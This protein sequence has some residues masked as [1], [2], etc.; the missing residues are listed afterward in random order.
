MVISAELAREFIHSMEFAYEKPP[1]AS[2][3][4]ESSAAESPRAFEERE[5][6][7]ARKSMPIPPM[8]IIEWRH[9]ASP[10]QNVAIH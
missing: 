9:P 4:G 6:S 5:G 7:A 10:H 8:K 3:R 2:A 1:Y